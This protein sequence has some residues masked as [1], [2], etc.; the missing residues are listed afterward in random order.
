MDA[1]LGTFQGFFNSV[2]SQNSYA[3]QQH[4]L[5]SASKLDCNYIIIKVTYHHFEKVF[6][7]HKYYAGTDPNLKFCVF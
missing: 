1:F 5:N 7:F 3:T 6:V 2:S 4:I